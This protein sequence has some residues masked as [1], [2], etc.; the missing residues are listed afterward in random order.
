MQ[1]DTVQVANQYLKGVD[2]KKADMG[3]LMAACRTLEV[4]VRKRYKF[5]ARPAVLM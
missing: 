3:A 4:K 5:N 2:Q 1:D